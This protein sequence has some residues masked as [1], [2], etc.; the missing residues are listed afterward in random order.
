MLCAGVRE[1]M[2]RSMSG[3]TRQAMARRAGL[4]LLWIL[5]ILLIPA[6]FGLVDDR[7]LTWMNWRGYI[8][9]F[10]LPY[11]LAVL[12]WLFFGNDEYEPEDPG[13]TPPR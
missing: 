3:R 2:E 11:A 13:A 8:L 6:G 5:A 12:Y 1:G 7:P 10:A 9:I 4:A